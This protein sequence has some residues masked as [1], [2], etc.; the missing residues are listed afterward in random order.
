MR[1]VTSRRSSDVRRPVHVSVSVR[2]RHPRPY[3]TPHPP[4]IHKV[5]DAQRRAQHKAQSARGCT[6]AVA[7]LIR[8]QA[9]P[10]LAE[11]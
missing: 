6:T 9:S 8:A 3:A 11:G 5:M 1:L 4:A 10:T 2:M 7:V